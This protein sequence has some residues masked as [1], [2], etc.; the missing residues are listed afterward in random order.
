MQLSYIFSY[1][2]PINQ[3]PASASVFKP[4]SQYLLSSKRMQILSS[5]KE[6]T[7]WKGLRPLLFMGG[8]N[9]WTRPLDQPSSILKYNWHPTKAPSSMSSGSGNCSI[10]QPQPTFP[11]TN[12][13]HL[14]PLVQINSH[15]TETLLPQL[16]KLWSR[17]LMCSTVVGSVE[18]KNKDCNILRSK[19]SPEGTR[20]SD[21]ILWF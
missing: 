16:G 5:L 8:M 11:A 12:N 18:S 7:Y 20:L 15:S 1:R 4:L 3:L 17:R 2:C 9:S 13:F 10:F 14:Y 19:F 21:P 6:A